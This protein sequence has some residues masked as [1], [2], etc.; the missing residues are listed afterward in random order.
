MDLLVAGAQVN[1][2]IHIALDGFGAE[3]LGRA[4]SWLRLAAD[5]EC[6]HHL[7]VWAGAGEPPTNTDYWADHYPVWDDTIEAPAVQGAGFEVDRSLLAAAVHEYLVSDHG[8]DKFRQLTH[9]WPDRL[10]G[11][12]HAAKPA[13]LYCVSLLEPAGSAL[14]IGHLAALADRRKT[15]AFLYRAHVIAGMGFASGPSAE[16][17]ERAR[18]LGAQTVIDLENLLKN[19]PL[20]DVATP[21]YLIGEQ[22]IDGAESDRAAQTALAAMSIVGLTRGSDG[23]AVNPFEFFLDGAGQAQWSGAPYNNNQPFAAIGG[24]AAWCPADRLA[25]LFSARLA[26]I[27]FDALASQPSCGSL[28]LAAKIADLPP[29]LMALVARLETETVRRLWEQVVEPEH[30]PWDPKTAAP[31]SGCFDLERVRAL[32][33]T[34]FDDREWQRVMGV[35]GE[36]QL[37]DIPLDSWENAFDDLEELIEHGV[38]PRRKQRIDLITHRVLQ[39]FLGSVETGISEIFA[40]AFRDPVHTLPH[41]CAQAYLGRLRRSLEAKSEELEREA[42]HDRAVKADAVNLRKSAEELRSE[43]H[44]SLESVP[45]PLAVFLRIAPLFVLGEALFFIL[46]F[47]LGWLNPLPVRLAAGALTGAVA[48]FALFIR[49]V[50]SIR[51]RLLGGASRW[52]K[53]YRGAL[54]L[55]DEELRDASYRGL[56]DSMLACL[57]WLYEGK[58][59]EPPLP[60]IFEPKLKR[61]GGKHPENAPSDEM[62]PQEPLSRFER[63]LSVTADCCRQL[64]RRFLADFQSSRLEV[65]LPDLSVRHLEAVRKEFS[66]LVGVTSEQ[67]VIPA[68]LEMIGQMAQWLDSNR[69]GRTWMMPFAGGPSQTPL[70]WRRSFLVP[71]GEELVETDTRA[72]SSGFQFFSTLHK[73]LE[74][75]FAKC[76]DLTQRISEYVTQQGQAAALTDLYHRYTGRATLSVPVDGGL[77]THVS[78]AAPSDPLALNL[79]RT[80]SLGGG[81]LSIH[82]QVSQH[83]TAAQ[84]IFYP[85][86]HEPLTPIGRAWKSHQIRPFSGHALS[87]VGELS[88]EGSA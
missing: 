23:D 37:R 20:S 1:F 18:V 84:A 7:Y 85:N 74:E 13:L 59:D 5:R 71:T 22:P 2:Y 38:L 36:P 47:D 52:L 12:D 82:L 17:E 56:L 21:V 83:I 28:E 15:G 49:Q 6:E 72:T 53:Q 3:A 11:S 63:Y 73:H 32:Y 68:A 31:P 50:E 87:A 77:L 26:T 64:E 30:I 40:L 51:N 81:F 60:R 86:E 19:R 65:A 61:T 33:G 8:V 34:I 70:L 41:R 4:C 58:E 29:G 54:D 42:A 57:D 35:Y 27:C 44:Q 79:R 25:R 46:P 24:F 45:S 75:R 16:R 48:G 62:P 55:E 14:L 39:T 88:K 66:S 80:N 76:F 78:G 67:D 43:L 69:D 9:D 10:L